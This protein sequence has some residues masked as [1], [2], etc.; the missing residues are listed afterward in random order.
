MAYR[1]SPHST[2]GKSPYQ[3]LFKREM[4]TLLNTIKEKKKIAEEKT[5][6]RDENLGDWTISVR[7]FQK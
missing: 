5:F 4:R 1:S 2:T 7:L 3:I 6:K